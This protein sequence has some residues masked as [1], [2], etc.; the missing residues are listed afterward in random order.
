MRKM[1][2]N[3]IKKSKNENLHL[4]V[5]FKLKSFIVQNY[6]VF[7][8]TSIHLSKVCRHSVCHSVSSTSILF[9]TINFIT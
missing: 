8:L 1:N 2:G 7:F 6:I 4:N 3:N 5:Y 9:I